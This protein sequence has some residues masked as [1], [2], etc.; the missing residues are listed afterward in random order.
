MQSVGDKLEKNF[1]VSA[2]VVSTIIVFLGNLLSVHVGDVTGCIVCIIAI[3]L[4]ESEPPML[5]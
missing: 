2:A 5:T 3:A 4:I 1:N